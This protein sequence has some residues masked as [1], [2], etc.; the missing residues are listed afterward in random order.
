MLKNG[1]NVAQATVGVLG[2]TFKENCPDV[3]NSKVVDII[4]ELQHWGL[5]VKVVDPWADPQEVQQEYGLTLAQITPQTEP[6]RV[7]RRLLPLKR[8]GHEQTSKVSLGAARAC[9]SHGLRAA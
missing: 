5:A 3:R 1:I 8:W 9:D 2:I 7:L 4:K 6:P